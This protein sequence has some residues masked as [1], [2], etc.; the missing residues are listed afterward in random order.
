[1][2][3]WFR[4]GV[5]CRGS[6]EPFD[7]FG[8]IIQAP[9]NSTENIRLYRQHTRIKILVY[10]YIHIPYLSLLADAKMKIKKRK[11]FAGASPFI[12]KLAAYL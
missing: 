9:D 10:I 12:N 4:P 3:Y 6:C 8:L 11:L 5:C 1:M 7:N 2:C